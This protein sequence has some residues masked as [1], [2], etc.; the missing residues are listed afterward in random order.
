MLTS[1]NVTEDTGTHLDTH[2]CR[3]PPPPTLGQYTLS[4]T[5]RHVPGWQPATEWC[6]RVLPPPAPASPPSYPTSTI[7]ATTSSPP[8]PPGGHPDVRR[9]Q[10]DHLMAGFHLIP[11]APLPVLA[12]FDGPAMKKK[13]CEYADRAGLLEAGQ[14]HS[15][16]GTTGA[17]APVGTCTAAL[18]S[19]SHATYRHVGCSSAAGSSKF[20]LWQAGQPPICSALVTA[21]A[22]VEACDTGS[23]RRGGSHR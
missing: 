22:P 6:G 5:F 21:S 15:Y 1:R 17:G 16:S 20:D 18:R 7:I 10:S 23:Y 12:P 8:P 9:C 3:V 2:M 13:H 19:G 11:S 14:R 4:H